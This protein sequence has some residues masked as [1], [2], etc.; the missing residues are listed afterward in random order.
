MLILTL[1]S[2]PSSSFDLTWWTLKD[3]PTHETA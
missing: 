3:N 1:M 2:T